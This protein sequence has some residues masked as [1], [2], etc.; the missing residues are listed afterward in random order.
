MTGRS[1]RCKRRSGR[2]MGSSAVAARPA[3]WSACRPSSNRTRPTLDEITRGPLEQPL[4]MHGL[5]GIIKAV[6]IAA[7]SMSVKS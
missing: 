7:E 4:P 6:Q 5:Q 2:P 1:A 3:S